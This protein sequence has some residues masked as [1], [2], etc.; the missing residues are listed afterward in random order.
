VVELLEHTADI[1]F[2]VRACTQAELFEACAGALISIA[3]ELEAVEPRAAYALEA[4]GEDAESLLVNWLNEALYLWDARRLAL[5]RFRVLEI[6]AGRV[7][8]EALGEPWDPERHRA[9]LLVK[10]VTYHQLQLGQDEGGWYAQVFVD[11]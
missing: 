2:R 7:A 8:G 5:R 9:R 4:A 6:G 10:G 1:G 3:I 11:V